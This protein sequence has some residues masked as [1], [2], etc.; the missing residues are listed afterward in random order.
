[1][2]TEV[3]TLQFV[4]V[5]LGNALRMQL[6]D[7]EASP[8]DFTRASMSIPLFFKPFKLPYFTEN[9]NEPRPR[10]VQ[11]GRL[12]DAGVCSDAWQERNGYSGVVPEEAVFCDGGMLSNFPMRLFH[13]DWVEDGRPLLPTI[14]VQLGSILLKT[15]AVDV[16]GAGGLLG[17]VLDTARRNMDRTFLRE[18][19]E[20]KDTLAVSD[21]TRSRVGPHPGTLWV[22]DRERM[23]FC[24]ILSVQTSVQ[25]PNEMLY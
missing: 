3:L 5:A 10:R 15:E 7:M 16:S 25:P 23:R 4:V 17:S 22:V 21:C 19:Q 13:N 8:A 6:Q 24:D 2:T 18:N 20:Y 9:F 14:G 12:L 11:V 1:V